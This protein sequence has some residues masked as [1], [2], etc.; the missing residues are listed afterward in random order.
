[1]RRDI[2]RKAVKLNIEHR[3]RKWWH[4][5][6]SMMAAVVVF[7]T[8][9]AL[10]LPAIT[11]E[12]ETICGIQAHSH[13]N[14]CYYTP[15][16]N[17]GQDYRCPLQVHSHDDTCHA[18]D[19]TIICGYG[20]FV[21][22]SHDELCAKDDGTM[23]C[24]LPV[25]TTHTHDEN[26][27]EEEAVYLCGLAEGE[28]GHSHT[29]V[30]WSEPET[31]CGQEETPGHAH[32]EACFGDRPLICGLT[33]PEATEAAVEES[34]EPAQTPEPA[35]TTDPAE[36][37]AAAEET[38]II[39]ITPHLHSENCYG[40]PELVCGMQA[41]EPHTHSEECFAEKQ[42]ICTQEEQ[43]GHIH[44]D[45]CGVQINKK[46]VC[47]EAE[48]T[49]HTH[50]ESCFD[51]NGAL[52]C[53]LLQVEAH[54]HTADCFVAHSHTEA[55]YQ[56][57]EEQAILI[58][59]LHVHEA[60][61]YDEAGQQICHLPVLI[62]DMGEHTHV[63][64]CYPE[65]EDGLAEVRFEIPEEFAGFV[66]SET[67]FPAVYTVEEESTLAEWPVVA[68]VNPEEGERF[69]PDYHWITADGFPVDMAAPITED[70]VLTLKIYPADEPEAA[71]LVNATFMI[72]EEAV[73]SQRVN[74]GTYASA[75][76][77]EEL[78]QQLEQRNEPQLRFEGWSYTDADGQ[79]VLLTPDVTVI[80][81]DTVYRAVFQRYVLITLHDIN[82]DGDEYPGSPQQIYL[83]AGST[84]SRQENVFLSDGT[85]IRSC[86]WYTVAGE[87][88]ALDTAVAEPLH[89][90]TYS[91]SLL[92][93]LQSQQS[94]ETPTEPAEEIPEPLLTIPWMIRA[95]YAAEDDIIPPVL[96]ETDTPENI[97]IVKRMG[98]E[99]TESDFLV[100]GVNYT[101][102]QWEDEEGND[103][104]AGDLVGTTLTANYA[105]AL[106]AASDYSVR[107][108]IN[109][110]NS[111]AVFGTRPTVGGQSS[112]EDFYSTADGNY[113]IRVPNPTQY[114]VTSGNKRTLYQFTGWKTARYSYTILAG[115]TVNASWFKTYVDK[116]KTYVTLTAQWT[117]VAEKETVHFFVNLNCQVA[118]V[119][120]NTGI[121]ASGD[122]TPSVYSTTMTVTGNSMRNYWQGAKNTGSSTQYIVLRADNATQTERIDAEI[123]RLITG[124][125]TT[126]EKYNNKS[127]WKS[128]Y[129]G[130]KIF[131]VNDFPSDENV[132]SVVRSMVQNGTV[133]R[134]N[135]VAL[136]AEELT[137]DN[138][139]VRWNVCKYDT[140]DG[141]HIDGILVGKQ[142]NITVKK[143]FQGDDAAVAQIKNGNYSITLDN[144]SNSS[145]KD[146]T[147]TLNAT[148]TTSG[149]YGYNAY[150]AN[151]DTYTWTVPLQQNSTYKI[152]ENNYIVDDDVVQ[153]SAVYTV[154]NSPDAFSG[155]ETYPKGGIANIKAYSYASDVSV[156]GYQTV[157]IRNSYVKSDTLTI[158]KIDMDTGHGLSGISYRIADGSGAPLALYQKPGVSYYS[159]KE[160]DLENGFVQIPD[161]VITTDNNGA[162][163]L[164]L[165]SGVFTLEEAFP[166]GYGGVS[167]ITVTVGVDDD[168]NVVFDQISSSD[169]TIEVDGTLIDKN[170]ATL[171]IRNVSFPTSVT[172][173]KIWTNAAEAKPVTVA[174]YRNGVDMGSAYQVILNTRNNWTHTWN[175]L[176]LYVDGAAA[177]YTLREIKIDNTNY[178]PSA[179]T[180]G[181]AGYIVAYDEMIYRKNGTQVP[182]PVW[183]DD[184]N[185]TQYADN[186]YLTVRNEVYRGQMMF[187]KVDGDGKPLPGAVF[188]LYS[189]AAQT[190]QIAE[191]T[192]DAYGR[193]VFENLMPDT[194][195]VMKE[196]DSPKGYVGGDSLYKI[197][198]T[199]QGATTLEDSA[200]GE[201]LTAIVNYLDTASVE[202]EKKSAFGTYLSDAQ[203]QLEKWEGETWVSQSTGKTDE[204][205]TLVLGELHSG[206]Y[207]LTEVRPPAGFMPIP[208]AIS[209]TMEQGELV[210]AN[211][212]ELWSVRTDEESG[213]III[214]VI[215][216]SGYVLPKTGG[217][218]VESCYA[219]GIALLLAAL[220]MVLVKRRKG[221]APY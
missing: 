35:E 168:G 182:G 74:A 211:P 179:D 163:F 80:E 32:S 90:Y 120:G 221:A 193:V 67:E 165:D 50:A 143:T 31:I 173:Q 15:V 161:S 122:F 19:G 34:T 206:A 149:R 3:R 138:F 172:A 10:I 103:V 153:T 158:N 73:L 79:E 133:I 201:V 169:S 191:A 84:L 139:T 64:S 54:Q 104:D 68:V 109:I 115:E 25:H 57:E 55:C 47:Q 22:H 27:F 99:L 20:D 98:V 40:D 145:A 189:D 29:D 160:E 150:D 215:N 204:S 105:L 38:E 171:T 56:T 101:D 140:G 209:F 130:T 66:H 159:M 1:M 44:D 190:K 58:C 72:G 77:S 86:Q 9:Y 12:Q 129:K 110:S 125:D 196:T 157:T 219:A 61:C 164:K 111:Q 195:Y 124:Y 202:I 162:I 170:T 176:P 11:M 46:L 151:T 114:M 210:I 4:R 59:P 88:F 152:I 60:D 177:K 185:I 69:L 112:L 8:T 37:A 2:L 128:D 78:L 45:S 18:E 208:G 75:L 192:S 118:D 132:L 43:A 113:T 141:W 95:A 76:L 81:S 126:D 85:D 62:C 188:R 156:T 71:K 186:A 48:L 36:P 184:K 23:V 142:A 93:D 146:L 220:A 136:K 154:S 212:H 92:L 107:Y 199:P 6:V 197:R 49:L 194:Y 89:L 70:M 26:C 127:V 137:S 155:W 174:L 207:R 116:G 183:T 24:A 123:R 117:P 178:D 21:V 166:T 205:G 82:P 106:A 83:P 144:T 16:L 65:E 30:C 91:Y 63:E 96:D 217:I 200:S 87:F 180:D 119:E 100:D 7:V 187:L 53:S 213:S 5:L 218:T 121:P 94:E 33:E 17:T 134:M 41:A 97:S 42:L 214:T 39:E 131:Q 13:T 181:Y 14:A 167:K 216:E 175:D 51:E 28:G 203:F 108:N 102:Y 147:L 198:L 148:E 135:N 52:V